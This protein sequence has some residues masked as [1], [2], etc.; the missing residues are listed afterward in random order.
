[1]FTMALSLFCE[2][3][4]ESMMNL[5]KHN[6]VLRM[7]SQLGLALSA[8]LVSLCVLFIAPLTIEDYKQKRP[9]SS[10]WRFS[11]TYFWPLT[12]E[13]VKAFAQV[14]FTI[15]LCAVPGIA[16]LVL[17]NFYITPQLE[18]EK[19]KLAINGVLLVL[20]IVIPGFYKFVRLHFLP[21]IVMFDPEYDK[22]HVHAIKRTH[23]LTRP[24]FLWLFLFL[25]LGSLVEMA[26]DAP[27]SL[28]EEGLSR[29]I[30]RTAMAPLSL[31]F[32]TYC[33][34]VSY[35]LFRRTHEEFPHEP[36]TADAG[37]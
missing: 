10:V 19:A 28:L 33:V 4:F 30:L 31:V 14:L 7:V 24:V 21:F 37:D 1:M 6:D 16:A 18:D 9:F 32:S 22:G 13:S 35:F 5:N 25:L 27:P 26:L 17:A 36:E 20:F 34:S 29:T 3:Y 23:L 15:C 8:L 12:L 2:M 11:N